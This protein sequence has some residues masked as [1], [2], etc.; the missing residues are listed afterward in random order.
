M[1]IM[2]SYQW[3][4]QQMVKRLVH[5]LQQR[6]YNVWLD[7]EMMKGS[8]M[9]AMAEAIDG[10]AV[11]LYAVPFNTGHFIS[12]HFPRITVAP[13]GKM[14]YFTGRGAHLQVS[15]AY[16]ESSNCR[17]EANYAHQQEVD[18]IPLMVQKNYNAQGWLGLILGTRMWYSFVDAEQDDEAA[19]ERRVDAV[20]WEVGERGKDTA[21]STSEGVPPAST[22]AAAP[23]LP[24]PSSPQAQAKTH[25]DAQAQEPPPPR[26]DQCFTPSMRLISPAPS[27]RS[28]CVPCVP[29]D[30]MHGIDYCRGL[31][32]LFLQ[33]QP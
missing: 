33:P 22:A 24:L 17:L 5:S 15:L 14:A 13:R 30:R 3:G 32:R 23:P 9:D 20:A 29:C 18:M 31:N 12:C 19:F 6:K 7:V 28:P 4:V 1:W 11:M 21:A 26:A 16:K 10:A 25:L 8:T 27:S 2:M